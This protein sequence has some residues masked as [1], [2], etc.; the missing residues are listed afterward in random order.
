MKPD[1]LCPQCLGR[2]EPL[3]HESVLLDRCSR[4]AGLWFDR[5][6]IER[7]NGFDPQFPLAPAV[8]VRGRRT[9]LRC[10]RCRTLLRESPYAPGADFAVDRC[11]DCRGVWLEAHEVAKVHGVLEGKS[12]SRRHEAAELRE[13]AARERGLWAHR[14]VELEHA[15]M[16]DRVSVAEWLFMFL[17]Q[18]PREV[19]HP[20][21]HFPAVTVTL[22]AL[23]VVV[24]LLE[25]WLISTGRASNLLLYAF[26]P[27]RLLHLEHLWAII[28]SQFLHAG[29]GHLLGNMYFLYTFGD[30]VE[31]ALGTVRFAAL[32]LLSG[33]VGDLAHF[34]SNILSTIPTVGASGAIAGLMGTY[35]A[36]FPRRRVYILIVFWPVKVRVLWYLGFWIGVQFLAAATSTSELGGVA[37]FAHIG[38]FLAGIGAGAFYRT[39]VYTRA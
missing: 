8:A 9:R 39:L 34:V 11:P 24:F 2:L 12:T 28:T 15:E 3:Q 17:T 23:N 37:W 33:V 29:L 10:P 6:E 22:I 19:H 16:S 30:N 18:L 25:V 21:H 31:D 26:V 14:E 7:F 4:C 20:T 27:E 5:G 13:V 32:Y 38:G 1:P 35:M 36:L